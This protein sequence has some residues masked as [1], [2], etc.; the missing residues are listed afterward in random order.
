MADFKDLF[1]AA[2]DEQDVVET[3]AAPVVEAAPAPVVAPAPAL[4]AAGARVAAASAD[5]WEVSPGVW[6]IVTPV[7]GA[8]TLPDGTWVRP[9]ESEGVS[10]AAVP[11]KWVDYVRAL[12][13]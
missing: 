7:T 13:R 9:T 6:Q 4:V 8:F 2:D 10:R 5:E 12:K 11:A 3:V 1:N